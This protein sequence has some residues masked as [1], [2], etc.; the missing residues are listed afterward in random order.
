MADEAMQ[1]GMA[2]GLAVDTG[3]E[4]AARAEL[5]HLA[6]VLARANRLY[7]TEDAPD[8]SDADY[9]ALKRRNARLRARSNA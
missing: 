5:A 8:I 4:S 7:H 6:T 3:E 1:S 9:D 2:T